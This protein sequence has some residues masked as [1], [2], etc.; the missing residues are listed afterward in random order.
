MIE[1]RTYTRN[2]MA[3]IL[4]TNDK[5]DMVDKLERWG[6]VFDEPKGRGKNLTFTITG[7]KDPFKVFCI[8]ELGML[9][10]CDFT[11]IRNLYYYYLNDEEFASLPNQVMEHRLEL[12]GK[13]IYRDTIEK[14]LT[15]LEDNRIVSRDAG[16][17]IYYFVDKDTHRRAEQAEYRKA[18]REYWLDKDEG[19]TSR[20]AINNMRRNYGGIAKKHSKPGFNAFTIPLQ[21]KLNE[22]ILESI[23]QEMVDKPTN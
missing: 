15:V 3:Q 23:E 7:I 5:G 13:K 14:Y 18:W 22:Y 11:K 10:S 19:L 9:A 17:N 8:T 1:L 16:D 4:S 12:E 21:E 20:E 2:E 6:V